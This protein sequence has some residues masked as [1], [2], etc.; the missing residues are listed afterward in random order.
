ME[1]GDV[2]E[3]A[4]CPCGSGRKPQQCCRGGE[5]A[6]AS[7]S[8]LD[9]AMR[10]LRQALK[11]QE[12]A[13]EEE[14]QAFVRDFN[15]Q[16][17]R[18]PLDD[19]SGLSPDQMHRLLYF[20]F[21][22]PQLVNLPTRVGIPPTAPILTLFRLLAEAIGEEGLKATTR[23]NL[24]RKFVQEAASAFG[25]EGGDQRYAP[26]G[27]RTEPDFFEL[28]VTRLVAELSGLIRKSK[29]RFVLH[30]DGRAAVND[31]TAASLYPRLFLSYVRDFNWAYWDAYP[32]LPFLQ[33]SF[34]FTLYLLAIHG[35]QWRPATFYEDA[36]VRAF[37]K[38]L[39]EVAPVSY[40]T[41]ES[42]IRNCYS[43]RVLER[44]AGFMGVAEI[45]RRSNRLLDRNVQVRSTPLLKETVRFR[46]IT[47]TVVPTPSEMGMP[48]NPQGRATVN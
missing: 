18:R 27:I 19:F 21:D 2:G 4:P 15:E 32:P 17:G 1:E 42:L 47:G 12:F 31:D 48:E 20:P 7:S 40:G 6:C 46:I 44:F 35:D 3:D 22:S 34:L 29:G 8:V 41:P 28:H 37:P 9:D 10:E 25:G 43:W 30:R 36:F 39:E 16:L 14:L 11:G 45:K 38:L 24:P 13:S 23:G 26:R 33:Q 5:R